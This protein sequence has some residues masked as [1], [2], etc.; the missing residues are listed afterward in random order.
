MGILSSGHLVGPYTARVAAVLAGLSLL[1]VGVS[2]LP[3]GMVPPTPGRLA[4]VVESPT[5]RREVSPSPSPS[6][7]ASATPSPSPTDT[8]T[9]ATAPQ[10]TETPTPEPVSPSPTA[11]PTSP[12]A[13]SPR[14]VG[15]NAEVAV[16]AVNVRAGPGTTYPVLA[17]AHMGEHFAVFGRNDEGTWLQI[18]C[19]EGERAWVSAGHVA[20][21][22]SMEGVIAAAATPPE[23]IPERA[24]STPTPL[25]PTPTPVP[26]AL[27]IRIT[28]PDLEIDAQVV[29]VGREEVDVQGESQ[30]Q[31]Q[32]ASFAAGHH[33]DS[34]AAGAAG[35][36]VISGHHN[37]EGRVFRNISLAWPEHDY[38]E[39][40]EFTRRSSVLD[41]LSV[42]LYDSA[43]GIHE[44]VIDGL[45]RIKDT[46]VTEQ[47]RRKNARFIAPTTEPT[48]TLITCWP[49][50][51]N[52][53][54]I[55]VT[56]R[57]A[58]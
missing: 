27:P 17:V 25:P 35:N 10:D 58:G 54:R 45:Y 15:L 37:I 34:A 18:C 42:F 7:A 28:I 50:Y 12:E 16:E 39:L 55:V 36:V 29:E 30:L 26:G 6:P 43:G 57:L 52:I 51:T 23:D 48:L 38:E 46:G 24:T 13:T 1:L 32:V 3:A 49:Y 4:Q 2:C 56:A 14:L 22:R 8:A 9:P 31:W 20:V 44:Y 47:Q 40:D 41:G 19:V 33:S 21:G 11:W 53:F 5:A